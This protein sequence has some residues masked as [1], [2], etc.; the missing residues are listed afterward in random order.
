[1]PV[2]FKLITAVAIAF[3]LIGSST[4]LP[5]AKTSLT[6]TTN[7]GRHYESR[8]EDG[9]LLR[10]AER[11]LSVEQEERGRFNLLNIFRK[12]FK[13]KPKTKRTPAF[14]K[15]VANVIKAKPT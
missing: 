14:K 9:R 2:P 4:S 11:A 6:S 13:G 10:G 1:M 5:M 3:L 8:E 12:L 7:Q 15:I